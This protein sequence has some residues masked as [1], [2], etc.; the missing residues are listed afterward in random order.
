MSTSICSLVHRDHP[1]VARYF[2]LVA[3][4]H[5]WYAFNAVN[6]VMRHHIA[7]RLA[8]WLASDNWLPTPT[9][10]LYVKDAEHN[11]TAVP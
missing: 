10:T 4:L 9:N 2:L 11:A 3:K 8:V 7:S 1:E 6:G 5:T